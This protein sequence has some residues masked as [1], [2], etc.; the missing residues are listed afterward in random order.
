MTTLDQAEARGVGSARSPRPLRADRPILSRQLVAPPRRLVALA[1]RALPD[2]L[3]RLGGVQRRPDAHERAADPGRPDARE[4]PPDPQRA[5]GSTE[6]GAGR[7][8]TSPYTSWYAN[9]LVI[10]RSDGALHG[11]PRRARRVCVQPLPLPGAADGAAV[12]AAHPDVPAVPRRRRDLP[13]SSS[14][15]GDVFPAFGLNT[16]TGS[17]SSTS[18]ARSASTPG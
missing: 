18:A 2:R 11:V 10:V 3:R 6:T 15:I 5:P 13:A 12:A 17:S 14:E 4:L 7:R 1:V 9:T 8:S 16:R